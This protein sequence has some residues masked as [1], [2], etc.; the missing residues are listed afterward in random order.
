MGPIH[1]VWGHDIVILIF[2]CRDFAPQT[3]WSFSSPLPELFRISGGSNSLKVTYSTII[4]GH[5]QMGDVQL[6][7]SVLKEMQRDARF[8]PDEIMYNLRS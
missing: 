7:F 4:K 6:G 2:L 1:P 5:C 3:L 8:K